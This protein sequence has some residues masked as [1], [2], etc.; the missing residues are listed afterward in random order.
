[1]SEARKQTIVRG[2][3]AYEDKFIAFVDILGFTDLVERP[4]SV[5]YILELTGKFGSSKEEDFA[6]YGPATCPCAPHDARDLNFRV[7]QISDCAVISAEVSPAGL[8]NLV[9]HCYKIAFR[10]LKAGHTC[11]GYI[12]RGDIYHTDAQFFGPGYQR[13]Y[14]HASKGKVLIFQRNAADKG[15]PFIEIDSDVC[16]YVAEQPDNCVK[17]VFGKLTESDG[18]STAIWPFFAIETMLDIAIAQDLD[19]EGLRAQVQ[20]VC[21][22]ILRLLSQL[23]N[24]KATAN[25]GGRRKIEHIERKLREVLD[26]KDKHLEVIDFLSQPLSPALNVRRL[27][28]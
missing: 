5:E 27:D 10:F 18:K 8:I 21:D 22:N 15:T 12:T 3:Q 11:I 28:K 16:R 6:R 25:N 23:E 20:M 19:A 4:A 14:D 24:A 7:T 1:V 13:A 2:T 26:L 17:T 9:H